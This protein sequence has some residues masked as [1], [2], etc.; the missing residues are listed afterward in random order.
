MDINKQQSIL[1]KLNF[2]NNEKAKKITEILRYQ[3]NKRSGPAPKEYKFFD[4]E[5]SFNIQH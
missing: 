5:K 4:H 3:E 2:L 1:D